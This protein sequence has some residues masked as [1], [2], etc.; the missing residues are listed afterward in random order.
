MVDLIQERYAEEDPWR[1]LVVCQLLNMT[2]RSQVEPLLDELFSRWPDAHAM[3]GASLVELKKF[4]RP[5]GNAQTK[6]ARI[7]QMSFEWWREETEC[8]EEEWPPS[9][10]FVAGLYGCGP[11]A[12]DSYNYFVIGDTSRFDSKDSKLAMWRQSKGLS[13]RV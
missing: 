4:I 2:Q 5:L 6:A 10:D 3:A 8:D 9:A 13:C 11:Y 1:M 7:V 12:V